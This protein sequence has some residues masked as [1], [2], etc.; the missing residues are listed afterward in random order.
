MAD[1]VAME[2]LAKSVLARGAD[3]DA[4]TSQG[5]SPLYL[6]ICCGNRQL[7]RLLIRSGSRVLMRTDVL[8]AELDVKVSDSQKPKHTVNVWLGS[9]GLTEEWVSLSAFSFELPMDDDGY[10]RESAMKEILVKFQRCFAFM[11][12]MQ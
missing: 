1:F 2:E 8:C 5:Y 4:T 7:S 3:V 6:A 10:I 11:R 9:G 12:T